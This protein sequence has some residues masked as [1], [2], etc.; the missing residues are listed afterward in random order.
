[1]IEHTAVFFLRLKC[2]M[3]SRVV[4]SMGHNIA[5]CLVA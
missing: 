5:G 1:M 2:V 4:G 3:G